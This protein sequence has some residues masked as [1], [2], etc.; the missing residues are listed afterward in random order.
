MSAD[1]H[2][3]TDAREIEEDVMNV[4]FVSWIAAVSTILIITSVFVLTGIYYFTKQ[5][6]VAER[7][8]D[9]DRRVS[10]LE[11]YRKL[12]AAVVDGV[13]ELP[14]VDLG[15]GATKRGGFSV[16]VERGMKQVIEA[17]Q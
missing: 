4:G 10:E 11:A 7:Q 15:E 1:T 12:D 9:A 8:A 2:A 3:G 16:P 17:G 13:Y 6:Q 14:E 5:R